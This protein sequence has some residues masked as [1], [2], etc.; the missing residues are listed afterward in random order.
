MVYISLVII[1]AVVNTPPPPIPEICA[2][3]KFLSISM[4]NVRRTNREAINICMLTDK[5]HAKMPKAA[6]MTAVWLAPR[7]PITPHSL[8]YSGV[9]VHVASKYLSNISDMDGR[10]GYE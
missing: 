8:P 9:K 5:P 6:K 4:A 7:R 3:I 1:L 10:E 2:G